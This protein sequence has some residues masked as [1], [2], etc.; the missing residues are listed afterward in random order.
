MK[1]TKEPIRAVLMAREN[2]GLRLAAAVRSMI[3]SLREGS[4][5]EIV[6]LEDGLSDNTR[7][8][9]LDSWDLSRTSIEWIDTRRVS[10]ALFPPVE[11][12]DAIYFARLAAADYLPSSWSRAILLDP[13]VLVL[14]DLEPLWQAPFGLLGV[15]YTAVHAD[16]SRSTFPNGGYF[17]NPNTPTHMI[18]PMVLYRFF[19]RPGARFNQPSVVLILNWYLTHRYR[20]GKAVSRAIPYGAIGF[21]FNGDL[22]GHGD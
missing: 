1:R 21:I 22:L 15:R 19:D 14:T 11:G 4:S 6:L 5:L 13:D 2:Y 12:L 10:A 16:Y 7:H 20:T 9:L 18:G 8:R 17:G 3:D